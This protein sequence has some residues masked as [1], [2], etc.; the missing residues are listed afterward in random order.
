MQ[1]ERFYSLNNSIVGSFRQLHHLGFHHLSQIWGNLCG[2]HGVS[3][4]TYAHPQL[5][6]VIKHLMGLRGASLP[7]DKQAPRGALFRSDLAWSGKRCDTYSYVICTGVRN[8][9]RSTR[10]LRYGST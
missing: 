2:G 1:F 7:I 4:L 6:Q 8:S 3:V 5:F 10:R 9:S